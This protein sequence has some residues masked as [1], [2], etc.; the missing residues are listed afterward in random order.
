MKCMLSLYEAYTAK[1]MPSQS[2]WWL[3]LYVLI[4]LLA[5]FSEKPATKW[6]EMNILATLHPA[7][8]DYGHM[9]IEEPKTPY[10]YATKD[11]SEDELDG[12]DATELAQRLVGRSSS[13]GH[14]WAGW[15]LGQV[16]GSFLSSLQLVSLVF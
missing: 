11:T 3:K 1:C 10:N 6:D 13:L 9:K 15:E 14:Q 4:L 12:L 5:F 2:T 7:D 8:K 16:K